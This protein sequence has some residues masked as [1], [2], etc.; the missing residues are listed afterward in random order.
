MLPDF[1]CGKGRYNHPENRILTAQVRFWLLTI[2]W[3][4]WL[5][6]TNYSSPTG[7]WKKL[8]KQCAKLPLPSNNIHCWPKVFLHSKFKDR[9]ASNSKSMRPTILKLKF[10]W[11][12]TR[13]GKPYQKSEKWKNTLWNIKSISHCNDESVEPLA[14]IGRCRSWYNG[15]PFWLQKK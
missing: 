9:I 1:W 2:F 10:M 5:S 14:P 8:H 7:K 3:L 13:I 6:K 12:V 11:C 15:L 4:L